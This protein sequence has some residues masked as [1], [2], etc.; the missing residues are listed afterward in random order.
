MASPWAVLQKRKKKKKMKLEH[1][2]LRKVVN[3]ERKYSWVRK[4][5]KK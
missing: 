4:R 1:P 5:E 3:P 2:S